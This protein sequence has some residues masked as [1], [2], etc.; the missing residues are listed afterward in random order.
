AN[1]RIGGLWEKAVTEV[2]ESADAWRALF[3]PRENGRQRLGAKNL[4]P[5][6]K[7]ESLAREDHTEQRTKHLDRVAW[8]R[9]PRLRMG[10]GLKLWAERFEIEQEQ[11]EDEVRVWVEHF[12]ILL[13]WIEARQLTARVFQRAVMLRREGQVMTLEELDHIAVDLN[14]L[15]LTPRSESGS[16]KPS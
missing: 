9:A 8:Q 1:D 5:L 2:I 13:G 4:D 16:G 10:E 14:Y 6:G 12:L 3:K 7:A 15:H 11:G